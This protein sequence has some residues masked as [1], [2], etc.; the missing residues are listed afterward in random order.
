MGNKIGGGI[1]L[2]KETAEKAKYWGKVKKHNEA[3]TNEKGD[4]TEE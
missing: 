4:S 1:K 3:K 2:A